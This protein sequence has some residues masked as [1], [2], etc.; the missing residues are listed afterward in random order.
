MFD[1]SLL[2]SC[3]SHPSLKGPTSR[4]SKIKVY[5]LVTVIKMYRLFVKL[6]YMLCEYTYPLASTD[7]YT[8][9]PT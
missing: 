4:S 6:N 9:K 1:Y 7:T 5:F 3:K 2:N 8:Y